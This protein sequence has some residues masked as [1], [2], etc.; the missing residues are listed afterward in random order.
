MNNECRLPTATEADWVPTD[1]TAIGARIVEVAE[2]SCLAHMRSSGGQLTEQD[3]EHLLV[4]ASK[5]E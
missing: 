2:Q 1:W 4:Q 5:S 3:I